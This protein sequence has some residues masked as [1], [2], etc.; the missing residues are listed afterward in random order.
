MIAGMTGPGLLREA[1]ALVFVL[2]CLSLSVALHSWA[3]G[4]IPPLLAVLAGGGLV[5]SVALPLTGRQ[6]GLPMI[7]GALAVTQLGLHLVFSVMP[8]QHVM[9]PA[10]GTGTMIA[11]HVVAGGLAALWLHA[12]EVAVW[13]LVRRLAQRLPALGVVF[14][15][16]ALRIPAP[17]P[18][19]FRPRTAELAAPLPEPTWLRSTTRRG[20]PALLPAPR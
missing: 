14:A 19:R 11:G 10:H 13:R 1:R 8:S 3:H 15:L 18:R 17:A 6:R 7:T 5:L 16:A 12:G 2:V 20:P 4:E 9:I